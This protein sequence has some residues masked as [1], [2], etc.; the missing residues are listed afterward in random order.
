MIIAN[1]R[2]DACRIVTDRLNANMNVS[3]DGASPTERL[4]SN[5]PQTITGYPTKI[6]RSEYETAYSRTVGGNIVNKPANDTWREWYIINTDEED[7]DFAEEAVK[8]D[9]QV[10]AQNMFTIADK[11]GRLDGTSILYIAVKDGKEASEEMSEGSLK[12]IDDVE[13]LKMFRKHEYTVVK[14]K[15]KS[16][17]T[18]GEVI[19]FKINDIAKDIHPSRVIVFGEDHLGDVNT[20]SIPAL[21]RPYNYIQ[22][23]ENVAWAGSEAAFKFVVPP[24]VI[25]YGDV[26]EPDDDV[27]DNIKDQLDEFRTGVRQ[28]VHIAGVTITP[29]TGSGDMVDIE[30]VIDKLLELIAGASNMP[31]RMISGSA[32]GE[33]SAASADLVDYYA[34]ISSRQR[35]YAESQV[36]RDYYSKM[37]MAGALPEAQYKITWQP[38][39][40][41]TEAQ[42]AEIWER[43]LRAAEIATGRGGVFEPILP[44]E[45]VISEI[46]GLDPSVVE[47][48]TKANMQANENKRWEQ[49]FMNTDALEN[50][51]IKDL[52]RFFERQGDDV[53][54]SIIRGNT[55]DGDVKVNKPESIIDDMAAEL[56]VII[57]DRNIEASEFGATQ[58]LKDLGIKGTADFGTVQAVQDRALR[59]TGEINETTKRAIREATVA[60]AAEGESIDAIAKRIS[61]VYSD[62]SINRSKTI[63][64]T[65]V[66]GASNKA[67]ADEY[68]KHGVEKKEWLNSQDGSVRDTH[69]INGE[70]VNQGERFSNGLY[71]PGDYGGGPEE[72]INCRCA[73]AP[74]I[75]EEK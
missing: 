55:I 5:D 72:V 70:I 75:E 63:A 39:F 24:W 9:R 74:V 34:S 42:I 58:A 4:L 17:E 51:Y 53:V 64:R 69:L 50:K 3:S 31:Q 59:V 44:M 14:D 12:S 36:V 65:E 52:R 57:R 21:K 22:G 7:K 37:Q 20:T 35:N 16:S 19:S 28:Q 8:L 71:Y 60:G 73:L 13:S 43:K 54:E 23:L 62:A 30:K 48:K 1:S 2:A 26:G 25:D 49:Y 67:R 18:F 46:L 33:L 68:I 27:V 41:M 56:Y 45:I 47:E 15:N 29:I 10:N 40:K 32:A 6:S 11:M 61:Q 66:V 38:L